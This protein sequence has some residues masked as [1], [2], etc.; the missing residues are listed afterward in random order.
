MNIFLQ[1]CM[2]FNVIFVFAFVFMKNKIFV[3][4]SAYDYLAERVKHAIISV[5]YKRKIA[6]KA[7]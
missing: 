4:F 7:N 5:V 3:S 6:N 2:K 1:Q